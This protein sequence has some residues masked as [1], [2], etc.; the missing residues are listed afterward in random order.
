MNYLVFESEK[1]SLLVHADSLIQ[2]GR[3]CEGSGPYVRSCT[4]T[5]ALFCDVSLFFLN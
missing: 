5:V 4:F 2:T 3:A 1:A